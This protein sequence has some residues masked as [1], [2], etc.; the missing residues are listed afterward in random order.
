MPAGLRRFLRLSTNPTTAPGARSRPIQPSLRLA[1]GRIVEVRGESRRLRQLEDLVTTQGVNLRACDEFD[2]GNVWVQL[3]PEPGN[4]VDGNAIMV[5]APQGELIGYMARER[6]AQYVA[7]ICELARSHELWCEA[8]IGG[9]LH[10]D[11]WRI[12]VWL[13]L[14]SPRDLEQ[15]ISGRSATTVA[16]LQRRWADATQ[17]ANGA[18]QALGQTLETLNDAGQDGDEE[19]MQV[20]RATLEKAVRAHEGSKRPRT[21]SQ[22]VHATA[23][24]QSPLAADARL[25][26]KFLYHPLTWE[27]SPSR[28]CSSPQPERLVRQTLV[29]CLGF[30]YW[31][32]VSL[33]CLC[34]SR[35]ARL[36]EDGR[37]YRHR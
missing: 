16:G 30:R 4:P 36:A 3:S 13:H 24:E 37:K 22:P 23:A 6:A 5:L 35:V 9:G 26:Q 15:Q 34:V 32:A 31:H 20:Q 25:R 33:P 21:R 19:S 28:A 1:T 14:P 29:K 11:G 8:Q 27:R 2:I 7:P 18:F 17:L 10:A 12:G